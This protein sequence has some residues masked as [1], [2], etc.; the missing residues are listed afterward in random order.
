MLIWIEDWLHG[1]R[2]NVTIDREY[3]NWLPVTSGV[4]QGSVLGPILFLVFINDIDSDIISKLLKFADD[5]KLAKIVNS[6]KD[7]EELG[8]DLQ[9][10]ED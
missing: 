10:L 4:P 5:S 9:K 7:A 2:Q 8:Q 3:S 1:R 6:V